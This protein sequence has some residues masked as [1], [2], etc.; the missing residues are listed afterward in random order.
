M[1]N[2]VNQNPLMQP[3]MF[4]GQVY[5]TSQYF[6]QQYR[7]NSNDGGKYAQLNNF[8]KLIRGIETY[9]NYVEL[10]DIVELEW[11]HVKDS[12]NSKMESL[13][14]LFKH[15]SYNPIMLINATAQVALTHHL[16]DEI[17][18]SISVSVNSNTA[19]ATL[20][21]SIPELQVA[22]SL[23]RMLNMS[24]TSKIRMIDKICEQRGIPS[25]FLPA[26]TDEQLTRS[27]TDL[28]KEHGSNLSARVVNPILIQLGIVEELT[29][30]SIGKQVKKFKSIT[31]YGLKFGKNETA[32]ENPRETQPRYF[33]DQFPVLLEMINKAVFVDA[34]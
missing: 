3:V 2:I 22:E 31:K 4:N 27:L 21:Q 13:K 23:A 8:N 16:D 1:N 17:S 24:D 30:P 20:Q 19:T 25:G 11:S 28:L 5:F 10:S 32:P 14:S 18:K 33:V 15:N 29:R 12:G 34:A 6:H 9:T 26:Y 7:A